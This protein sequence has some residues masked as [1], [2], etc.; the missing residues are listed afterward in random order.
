MAPDDANDL[1]AVD[2]DIDGG[3]ASADAEAA[4]L[5]CGELDG[6]EIDAAS[7]A[8]ASSGARVTASEFVAAS[9]ENLAGEHCRVEGVIGSVDP[10][11]QGIGFAMALP[12][13]WNGKSIHAGGGGWNGALVEPTMPGG[14]VSPNPVASGF[15][16]FGSDGG[17]L[18]ETGDA[19]FALNAEQL[20]NFGGDQLKKTHDV[21]MALIEARYAAVPTESYFVGGSNG[22]RE[23]FAVMQNWPEDYD[24]VVTLFPAF[25]W[26]GL[27]MKL[28]QIGLALR[29]DGGAGWFGP[30]RALALREAALGACDDLDGLADGL[31]ADRAACTFDPAVLLCAPDAAPDEP[32]FSEAQVET[33]RV[34]H[35]R[36]DLPYE[37]A[38]GVDSFPGFDIGADWAGATNTGLAPELG[39][40]PTIP[41]LGAAHWFADG[42][43]RY[44][45]FG[46]AEADTLAFDPQA[47]GE[48]L[49]R[50]QEA[51]AILDHA[52]SDIQAYLDRGGKLVLMHGQS[53]S[54]VNTAPSVEYVD[55]LLERF[56]ET[57]IDQAIRFYLVPGF[58]HGT[59]LSFTP[60]G[61]TE[62][63]FDAL[64]RW[65]T[66]GVAPGPITITDINPDT[67]GRTRPLC[68]YP[69]VPRYD[70]TGD[71]DLAASFDCTMP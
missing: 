52:D 64:D 12:S 28:Q 1:P 25:S 65:V 18:S 27:F 55:A 35:S 21:A 3:G 15:V 44:I 36:L 49:P 54:L 24:G 10:D 17:H 56:G 19:A 26:T 40:P 51:S 31:I 13:Q 6:R 63:L 9:A 8:L 59:G 71:V 46:D 14:L 41:E 67:Q 70:D 62:T 32:C 30:E 66:E 34:M 61:L 48:L 22:G 58:G 37:L 11:A 20:E 2:P 5:A 29:A 42:Y 47:P 53:D 39:A 33:V 4:A 23:S 57:T 68:E 7:I 16:A 38:D 50:L 43:V 60:G 69:A 45:L